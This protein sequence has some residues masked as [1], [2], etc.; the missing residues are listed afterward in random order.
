MHLPEETLDVCKR[1]DA[2]LFGAVGGP[3]DKQEGVC[4]LLLASFAKHGTRAYSPSPRPPAAFLA[5]PS[6]SQANTLL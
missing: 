3:V 5:P 4:S 1:S 2:I 6:P